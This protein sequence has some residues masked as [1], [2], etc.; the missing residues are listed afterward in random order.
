MAK[1]AYTFTSEVAC[2]GCGGFERYH[3]SNSC[4]NCNVERLRNRKKEEKPV[5]VKTKKTPSALLEK[6]LSG[7]PLRM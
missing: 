3:G 4:R 1:R 5:V 7:K 2:S 6:F